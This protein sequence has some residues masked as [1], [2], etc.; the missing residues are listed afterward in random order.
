M[1]DDDEKKPGL[2]VGVVGTGRAN[3][4]LIAAMAGKPPTPVEIKY[5]VSMVPVV[6]GEHGRAWVCNLKA[7]R[8]EL[9][10]G[11]DVDATLDHWVVEAPWAH[12]A[13]HSYS[14]VLVHLRPMADGRKTKFYIDDATHEM[15]VY[16]IDPQA[17]RNKLIANGLVK[18]AWLHPGNFAAQFIEIRDELA[19]E[20]IRKAVQEICDGRL[21]PDTDYTRMWIERFGDNMMR[22]RPNARPPRER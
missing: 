14:I 19:R 8:R 12:P 3:M 6:S 21:S 5:P 22:D 20:R 17:N 10:I 7:G 1:S 16:A 13:W 15:W 9:G 4:E 11:D 2:T 18:G